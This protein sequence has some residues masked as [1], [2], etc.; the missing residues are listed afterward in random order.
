MCFAKIFNHIILKKTL[1]KYGKRAAKPKSLSE[2]LYIQETFTTFLPTN[3]RYVIKFMS[4]GFHRVMVF[5]KKPKGQKEYKNCG[6]GRSIREQQ[7]LLIASHC[8]EWY[9]SDAMA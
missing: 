5:L 4:A 2:F 8:E 6:D 7:H 9:S 1:E 3:H